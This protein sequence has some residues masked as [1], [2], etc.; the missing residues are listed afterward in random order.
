MTLQEH[1]AEIERLNAERRKIHEELKAIEQ[2][3]TNS[4]NLAVSECRPIKMGDRIE[5]GL[6]ANGYAP[7][8]GK[9][10]QVDWTIPVEYPKQRPTTPTK[11][12]PSAP[13]WSRKPARRWS[14]LRSH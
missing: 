9:T 13:A 1:I 2:D 4:E 10:C 8:K 14:C 6:N 7:H 3:I 11:T 5:V 12:P